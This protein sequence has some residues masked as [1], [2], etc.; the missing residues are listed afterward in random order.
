MASISW[1]IAEL[2]TTSD[3]VVFDRKKQMLYEPK[4]ALAGASYK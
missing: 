4:Y 2:E 1:M 3:S